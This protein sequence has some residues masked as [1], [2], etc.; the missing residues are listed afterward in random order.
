MH[1]ALLCTVLAMAA[2]EPLSPGNSTRT[3]QVAGRERSYIVHVPAK[4]DA[5]KPTPVVLIFH[6]AF[7][8]GSITQLY[9]G[10]NRTAD[11]KDFIAVYP[12]GTGPTEATLFWNAGKWVRKHLPDPPDDV[13]FVRALLD[14][15]TSV[16]KVDT[17]RTFATGISNGGMMCYKLAA[18]LSDR[19]AAIAPIA[20]TL[21]FDNP[22]PKRPVPVIH[23]HGTEDQLVPYKG[24]KSASDKNLVLKSVDETIRTWVK[25]N[26]CPE[27][28][29][30]ESLPNKKDDGTTVVRH[31]YSPGK[32]NSEVVLIEIVGGGHTWPG[33]P[34]PLQLFGR[35]THDIYANDML[36]DFFEQHPMP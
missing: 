30:V 15:L 34:F 27:P 16:A 29:A 19:I 4:Y 28:A 6:G 36:W 12:N 3:L 24:L 31:V 32:E 14:D 35:T 1:A 13:Q 17:K 20:G 25:L 2:S 7:T 33:R 18:E 11:E 5:T 10:M 9:S 21:A 8:N 26:G 22:Q 23:F